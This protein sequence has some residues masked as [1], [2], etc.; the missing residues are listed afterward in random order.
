MAA[1]PE[2][3]QRQARKATIRRGSLQARAGMTR[4]DARMLEELTGLYERAAAAMAAEIVT[5]APGTVRAENLAQMLAQVDAILARL[6]GERNALLDEGMRQAAG[7]GVLPY[8][9]SVDAVTLTR[10]AEETLRWQRAFVAEDGLQLS[11]RLWRIDASALQDVN[12]A[13]SQAVI[14]GQ[15]ASA[16]AAEFLA[17]GEAVPTAVGQ[18]SALNQGRAVA[19]AA[20]D[21]LMRDPGNAYEQAKRLFRTEIN[22]SHGETYMAAGE[23]LEELGGFKFMLSPAHPEP[24]IC[25]LHARAN[26]HG[27]GPGVYPSREA[28]PWPAHPNTLS[29]VEVVFED[30]VTDADRSARESRAEWLGRQ[31]AGTR[32]AVLGGKAKAAAFDAGVLRENQIATPWQVLERRYRRQGVDVDALVGR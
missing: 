16:A 12:T 2:A 31:P 17:R 28:C 7:L 5:A 3:L 11:D 4:L 1:T 19:Q 27:L 30:E 21:A 22:R 24:D 29:F 6:S 26:L 10:V 15:G 14:R 32:E 23:E 9:A 20:G 8:Q 18:A 25:D 13:I